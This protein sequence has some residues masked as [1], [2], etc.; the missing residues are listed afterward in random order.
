[1]KKIFNT[2]AVLALLAIAFTSCEKRL[3]VSNPNYFTDDQ[4]AEY[5]A[6]SPEAE[7]QVLKGLVGDL[8]GYINYYNADMNG[9]YSNSYAWESNFELRRFMQSG[10][11]VEGDELNQGT[12]TTWY[13]NLA[14]NTY[15]RTNDDIQNYGYYLGPVHKLHPAQKALDFLTEDKV[16]QYPTMASSRAQ[17]LTLKAIC[18]MLLMERYTDLSDVTSTTRQGWPVYDKFDYNAAK[19][20]LSVK[21]TWEYVNKTFKEAVDLF[22]NSTLGNQGYTVGKEVVDRRYFDGIKAS[23]L[24]DWSI[25]PIMNTYCD[26]VSFP[27]LLKNKKAPALLRIND[28]HAGAYIGEFQMDGKTYNVCEFTPNAA[29]GDGLCPSYVDEYGR[30]LTHKNGYSVGQW[31]AAGYFTGFLDY[32][33][34]QPDPKPEKPWSIDNLAVY[35]MRGSLP[36]GT[37]IPQGVDNRAALFAEYG[38]S[39]EETQAAQDIVNDVYHKNK[40][41]ITATE[42]AMRLIAGEGGD[43]VTLRR[44]WVADTYGDQFEDTDELFRLAQDKVNWYLE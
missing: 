12:Y 6:S 27:N 22:H 30:R 18:Y 21:E 35:I 14:S 5:M 1:M 4:M 32:D 41:D 26:A 19:E 43:G 23:G 31:S 13:Q 29:L 28:E 8:P 37:A 11:V 42:I 24:G 10:D 15:W 34:V 33:E 38:Y 25:A 40:M 9:G 44:Q 3:E 17:A 39:A 16:K 20:P 7:Q 36:D 2:L